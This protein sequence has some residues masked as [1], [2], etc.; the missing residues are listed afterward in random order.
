MYE[1]YVRII[2]NLILT[3]YLRALQRSSL[4]AS[5]GLTPPVSLIVLGTKRFS[6]R[7]DGAPPS[8]PAG[9]PAPA[10]GALGSE[11]YATT[12]RGL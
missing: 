12:A 11:E 9:A 6:S 10:A 7:P 1:V 8:R 3:R 5:S 2:P 4:Q